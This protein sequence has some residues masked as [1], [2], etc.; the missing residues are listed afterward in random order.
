MCVD[1]QAACCQ[2]ASLFSAVANGSLESHVDQ[3]K[4]D[5]LPAV[6]GAV[7]EPEPQ[8]ELLGRSAT[9]ML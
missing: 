7:P 6:A 1:S 4:L 5:P 3:W 9:W 2:G 8:L